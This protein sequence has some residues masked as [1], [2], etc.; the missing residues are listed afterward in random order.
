ML[1]LPCEINEKVLIWPS[2]TGNRWNIEGKPG[3]AIHPNAEPRGQDAEPRGQDGS[4]VW[5]LRLCRG[6][7]KDRRK[8]TK[9]A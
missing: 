4:K 2:G 1:V 3:S 5:A 9:L 6:K 7:K 8:V